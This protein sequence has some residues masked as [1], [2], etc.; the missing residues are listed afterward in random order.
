MALSALDDLTRLELTRHP[1]TALLARAF[2]LRDNATMY[3]ALYLALAE[4]LEA[5]LVTRDQS[6]ARIPGLDAE[7]Q[8]IR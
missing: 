8:V 2:E 5:T 7:V 4:L 1:H 3:D 6:L